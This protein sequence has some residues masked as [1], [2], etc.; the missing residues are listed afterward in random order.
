MDLYCTRLDLD[1]EQCEDMLYF[2]SAMDDTFLE[3]AKKKADPSG[4]NKGVIGGQS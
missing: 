1:E 2:I 4:A 3:Y